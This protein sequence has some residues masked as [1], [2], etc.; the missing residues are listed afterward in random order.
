M[1]PFCYVKTRT[2]SKFHSALHR[3]AR[4]PARMAREP[5]RLDPVAG[6]VVFENVT[7][8]YDPVRLILKGI[9]FDVRP[10][11]MIGLVGPSGAGKTGTTKSCACDP[12]GFWRGESAPIGPIPGWDRIHFIDLIA[13]LR[14]VIFA[15]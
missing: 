2:S 3:P 13:P 14:D 6:R 9:S 4:S 10:G 15:R 1:L 5:V 12:S 8:G 7:F 11:E